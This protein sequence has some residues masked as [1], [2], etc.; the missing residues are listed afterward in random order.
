MKQ[1][2]GIPMGVS[3]APYLANLMLFMY[4]F[5]YFKKFIKQHDPLRYQPARDML[6]YLSCCTRYIDD[7][8]NPLVH[9]KTFREITKQIYPTWLPLGESEMSGNCVNYLDMSIYK[10]KSL[11]HSKLYSKTGELA[12]KGLKTNKFPHHDSKLTTRCKYGIITSQYHRFTV[13]CTKTKHWL[14]AATN[15]YSTFILN[16]KYDAKRVDEYAERFIKKHRHL[17]T[18]KPS[19]VAARHRKRLRQ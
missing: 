1:V 11:W 14:E 3:C 16:K 18:I 19:A 15:L 12:A 10:E 2:I 13:A 5:Q 17:L 7:L 9:E 8:W 4:E 6:Q